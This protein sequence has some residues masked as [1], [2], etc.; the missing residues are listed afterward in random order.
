MSLGIIKT[1]QHDIRLTLTVPNNGRVFI[2][3]NQKTVCKFWNDVKQDFIIAVSDA[4]HLNIVKGEIEPIV[5]E[6]EK[7]S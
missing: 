1:Q 4:L 6:K 3:G 5:I 7:E 2:E